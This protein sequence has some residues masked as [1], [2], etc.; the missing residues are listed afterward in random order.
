MLVFVYDLYSES[1]KE[2][3]ANFNNSEGLAVEGLACSKRTQSMVGGNDRSFSGRVVDLH[4]VGSEASCY[5]CQGI[6]YI[7]EELVW[8][9]S[10]DGDCE[11]IA[12][13]RDW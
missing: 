11:V 7:G 10:D 2:R 6:S 9:V 4:S 1:S 5:R 13:G 8:E 3:R 12:E